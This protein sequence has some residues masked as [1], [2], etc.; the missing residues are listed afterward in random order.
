VKDYAVET[1][2]VSACTYAMYVQKSA[3][4]TVA[5]VFWNSEDLVLLEFMPHQYMIDGESCATIMKVLCDSIKQ[6]C[7]GK[8]TRSSSP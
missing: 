2:M 7:R 1:E 3:G 5:V 8:L 6:I 4:R